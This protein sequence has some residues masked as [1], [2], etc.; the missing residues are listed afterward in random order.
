MGSSLI[1]ETGEIDDQRQRLVRKALELVK[2]T[3][4]ALQE[5]KSPCELGCGTF[6]LGALVKALRRRKL[7]W[8]Q[9]EKPYSGISLAGITEAV[10]EAQAQVA[11][12]IP[13]LSLGAP[14][15]G[16]RSRTRKSRNA[17]PGQALTP[18][19]SPEQV[20]ASDVHEC[21]AK[22]DLTEKLDGLA[23][24]V[25]GLQLEGKLGFCLY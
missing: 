7:L 17:Q 24:G 8:P 25:E 23:A 21:G 6:L 16:Q 19:S 20:A 15:S 18:D 5:D 11:Q 13:G 4:D 1:L 14:A 22:T 9:P 10:E 12:F 2:D 3:I